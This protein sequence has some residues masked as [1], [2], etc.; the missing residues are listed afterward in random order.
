MTGFSTKTLLVAAALCALATSAFAQAA[1]PMRAEAPKAQTGRPR[2]THGIAGRRREHDL[3]SVSGRADPGDGVH[4]HDLDRARRVTRQQVAGEPLVG[5]RPRLR[6]AGA[7]I[8]VEG[9]TRTYGDFVAVDEADRRRSEIIV[10]GAPRAARGRGVFSDTVDFV[11][12]HAPSRVMVV[13]GRR[14]A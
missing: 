1:E 13:A 6:Q 12:K 11:L 3:T 5:R 7:M 14:A 8:R 2:P 10:M 9:L 4:G